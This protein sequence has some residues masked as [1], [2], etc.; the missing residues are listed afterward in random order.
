M[1]PHGV[2]RH[3]GLPHGE[4]PGGR[5][6][7]ERPAGGYR[8]VLGII[9]SWTRTFLG[10]VFTLTLVALQLGSSRVSPRVVRM[11]VRSSVTR[12]AFGVLLAAF[13]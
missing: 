6:L 3:G 7:A 12:L 4:P 2:P 13:S 9:A 11:F 1:P 5:A 10:V 8:R